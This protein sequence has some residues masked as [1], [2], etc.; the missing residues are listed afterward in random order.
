MAIRAYE[1]NGKKLYE[2]YVNGFD[3]RGKRVQ[4]RKRGIESNRKAED[5]HFDCERE[6]AKLREEGIPYTWKEWFD[7]A[8]SRM[9]LDL[10]ASTILN[11]ESYLG[12]WVNARWKDRELKSITRQDVFEVVLIRS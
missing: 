8:V 12:E 4:W 7:L 11:Y 2:V 9:R 3:L 1:A 6:L 10:R 5:I